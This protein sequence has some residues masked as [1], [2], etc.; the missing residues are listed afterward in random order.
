MASFSTGRLVYNFMTGYSNQYN[1]VGFLKLLFDHL[2]DNDPDWQASHVMILDN[3]PAH[4]PETVKNVIQGAGVKVI[5]TAPA[6][7]A[8]LPI[9]ELFGRIKA[10]RLDIADKGEKK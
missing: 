8:A 10:Q 1:F 2:N 7:F 3:A 6:S 5:Y 4:T 9:E